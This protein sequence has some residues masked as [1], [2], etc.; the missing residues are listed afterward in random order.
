[1]TAVPRTET[2]P[3]DYNARLLFF[4]SHRELPEPPRASNRDIA[5]KQKTTQTVV[6]KGVDPPR[7]TV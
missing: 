7:T 2:H 3:T 1:M 5:I 4:C 6:L